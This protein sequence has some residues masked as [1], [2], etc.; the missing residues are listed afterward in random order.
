[1]TPTFKI[2]NASAGSGKTFALAER[3]LTKILKSQ[4]DDYFKRILALTF[5]NKAAQEMKE[6]V[7]YSLKEFSIPENNKNPSPLFNEVKKRLNFSN[8]EINR[9]SK[10]RLTKILHDFSFFQIDTLDS[11]SHHIIRS[12]ANELNYSSDFNVT[13]DNQ[14]IIEEAVSQVFNNN[15][16]DQ[17]NLL[18]DF[19]I[20]KISEGKSWDVEHDLKE[21]AEAIF[22][23]NQFKDIEDSSSTSYKGY[24]KLKRDLENKKQNELRKKTEILQKIDVFFKAQEFEIMF[25]RNAFPK[26]LD[27]VKENDFTWK[28]VSSIE[29]LFLKGTLIKNACY[30]KTPS[31]AMEFVTKT[32]GL[33]LKLKTILVN[34]STINS[35]EN[36]VTPT[37]LLK[38]IKKHFKDIQKE[39]NQISISEFNEI[40]NKEIRNQPISFLYE[41][42][43]C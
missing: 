13:I 27:K 31:Q 14:D 34:I 39:K 30:D 43:G 15:N 38:T 41:K 23:E 25:T 7:L 18:I 42:L 32:E 37:A 21:F 35:F 19:A 40:I 17:N 12:F 26:F 28:S 8:E 3:V 4:D 6:R 10:T 29:S 36:S 5:T 11:F 2:I 24:N 16:K 20:K 1:L 9:K 22:N 33:F